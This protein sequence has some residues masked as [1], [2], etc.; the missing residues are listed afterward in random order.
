MKRRELLACSAAA[1]SFGPIATANT[2]SREPILYVYS[3]DIPQ[4]RWLAQKSTQSSK[5]LIAL[6]GDLMALWKTTLNRRHGPLHGVTSW[7]DYV[8]L[9]GLAEE[10]GLRLREEMQLQAEGKTLFRWV[11]A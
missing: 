6:K 3:S 4:A 1:L 2:V 9:R 7:S 8:L 11:M 10:H 5:S